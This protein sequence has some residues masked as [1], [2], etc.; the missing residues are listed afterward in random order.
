MLLIG[1]VIVLSRHWVIMSHSRNDLDEI[2]IELD[3]IIK[4][5]PT[6]SE[7]SFLSNLQEPERKKRYF[8]CQFALA[9]RVIT[10]VYPTLNP[11]LIFETKDGN[12]VEYE[13]HTDTVFNGQFDDIKILLVQNK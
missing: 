7:I 12:K 13:D 6:D 8:Q 9:P 4:L 10:T 5:T 3:Q 2:S 1:S 11:I